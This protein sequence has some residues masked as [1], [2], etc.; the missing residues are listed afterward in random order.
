VLLPDVVQ[1]HRDTIIERWLER[2]YRD[3]SPRAV[4]RSDVLDEL[5]MVLDSLVR[6]LRR[7]VIEEPPVNAP[8]PL[9]LA[10]SHGRQRFHAGFDIASVVREHLVLRDVI[11]E[12]VAEAGY[13]PELHE[14]GSV[15][16]FLFGALAESASTYAIERDREVSDQAERYVGFL[17]H[18]LRNPL[19]TARLALSLLREQGQLPDVSAARSLERALAKMHELLD[20]ALTD[21]AAR[22]TPR[23]DRRP[24][25]LGRFLR[26]VVAESA[27]EAQSKRIS[28]SVEIDRG[29]VTVR[30]DERLLRS[31]VSNLVRNAIKFSRPGTAVRVTAKSG[32]GHVTIEVLDGCGGLPPGSVERLF[33][34]FVQAGADR[35]GFGLGLAIAKQVTDAHGGSLRVHDLP[36]KGCVFLLDLPD[37]P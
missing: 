29:D 2:A 4:P 21:V 23:A 24:L 17:A 28:A 1:Q 15:A 34:P 32:E 27:A 36:G 37:A 9:D 25:E 18:E 16:R 6:A 19:G 30:A 11:F 7:D 35:T 31:A 22:Q 13:R 12:V 26:E 14:V 10:Q 3:L 33:N 8:V 5:G 20:G